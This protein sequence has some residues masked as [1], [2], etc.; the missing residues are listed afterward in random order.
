[1]MK[2]P[3]NPE[4]EPVHLKNVLLASVVH[5]ISF[6]F[7]ISFVMGKL[8]CPSRADVN[9]LHIDEIAY[10]KLKDQP[11]LLKAGIKDLRSGFEI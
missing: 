1:M 2:K 3:K 4:F 9:L 8:W 6:L 5:G 10:Q 7:D 11:F